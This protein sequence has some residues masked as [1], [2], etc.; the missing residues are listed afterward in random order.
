MPD[1]RARCRRAFTLIELLVV[2]AIIA[3]LIALLLPAVQ[4]VRE[5]AQRAQCENNLH[6]LALAV[7]N[8]HDTRG[9]M[10]P[11][12]GVEPSGTCGQYPWCNRSAPYGGWLVHLLPFIEQDNL[13]RFVQSDCTA[14]N[15]NEPKYTGGGGQ[16]TCQVEHYNGHDLTVCWQ[17][18]V[19]STSVDG[20]WIEGAHQAT[21]KTLQCPADPTLSPKGLVY[22]YWGATCYVANWNAWGSGEEGLWTPP[23]PFAAIR[24]GLSNTVLFGEAYSTCDGLGRIGLYSWYYHNFGLNQENVPNTL[25]FQVRPGEETCPT[26]CDNWRAQTA[27]PA[28]NVALVDGSVRP[29]AGS[30]S[31]ETWDRVLLPRDGQ[32][33]GGDW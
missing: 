19:T 25:M 14:N 23:Q 15:Y 5:A 9:H 8:Y 30:V 20:I 21:Y 4:K 17:N 2:I 1:P 13:Y 31:Q 33:L 3:V 26:C 12:F 7:H 28:M 16:V 11:Y 22:N 6:Q 29:V 18:G 32:V 27:H 24:D 10:P